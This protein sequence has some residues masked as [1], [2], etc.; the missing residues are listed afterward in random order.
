MNFKLDGEEIKSTSTWCLRPGR[1]TPSATPTP[2]EARLTGSG[3]PGRELGDG[4]C[5]LR[6]TSGLVTDCVLKF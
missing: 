6:K 2:S 5:E 3:S 4:H 1:S